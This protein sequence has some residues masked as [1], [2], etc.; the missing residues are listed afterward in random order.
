[1]ELIADFSFRFGIETLGPFM[2]LHVIH[3]RDTGREHVPTSVSRMFSKTGHV[4]GGLVPH[5]DDLDGC[6]SKIR[7]Q[8]ELQAAL[9]SPC[10]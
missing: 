6:T 5:I 1:M 7:V 9:G 10:L 4:L 8:Y 2:H 3:I